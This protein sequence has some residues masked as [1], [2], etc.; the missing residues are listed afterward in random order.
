[1]LVTLSQILKLPFPVFLLLYEY[2]FFHL[3][4]TVSTQLNEQTEVSSSP[5]FSV[6]LN[7]SVTPV[8]LLSKP[9]LEALCE[10][11]CTSSQLPKPPLPPSVPISH[12]ISKPLPTSFTPAAVSSFTPALALSTTD[13][14]TTA[15]CCSSQSSSTCSGSKLPIACIKR[16]GN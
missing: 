3:F 16:H 12:P 5:F 6:P 15:P 7:E 9:D 4:L 1:M 10:T 14:R 8:P 13:A 2:I 11:S